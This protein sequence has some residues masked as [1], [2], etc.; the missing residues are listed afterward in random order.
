MAGGSGTRFWPRSTSKLPKQFLALTDKASMIQLTARRLEGVIEPKKRIVVATK[1]QAPLIRKQLGKIKI[2]GEPEGR[3]TMA[4]VCWSAW[5]I[6][7]QDP[8]AS[9]VVLP[10]DAHIGDVNAYKAALKAAFYTAERQDRI[11]CLGIKPTHPATGYGYIKSGEPIGGES[12]S[13]A[14]FVE[15]PTPA[16]AQE[17]VSSGQYLWN[18]GIFV[19]KA[20]TFVSEARRLAPEFATQFDAIVQAPKKLAAIY[21]KLPKEPVDKALMEKT[22]KGAVNPGDFGWNDV[23]SWSALAEVLGHN[24]SAG[25]IT[26]KGGYASVGSENIYAEL[27]GDKFLGLVGVKDLVIVETANALLVCHK[28]KVQDIKNLVDVMKT[29]PKGKKTL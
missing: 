13:I 18:A 20:A 5:E 8:D 24:T 29:H 3:N 12:F 16:L 11:V 14:Q 21:R 22:D 27:A 10:A 6:H 7:K 28:D 17:F 19:F 9:V 2:L 1:D 15:K 25:R 4:A 23:G 26:A